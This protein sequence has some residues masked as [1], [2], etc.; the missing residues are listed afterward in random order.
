V[1]RFKTHFLPDL[2]KEFDVKTI[3]DE[4]YTKLVFG[5]AHFAEEIDQSIIPLLH[6]D[7]TIERLGEVERSTIRAAFI[8]LRDIQDIPTKTIITEY[9]NIADSCSADSNFVNAIL[10]KLARQV[11]PGEMT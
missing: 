5:A 10:D 9:T 3:D 2:L 8:E 1:P 7:W 6:S 4:H 11:R